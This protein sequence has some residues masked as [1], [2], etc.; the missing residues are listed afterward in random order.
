MP[1]RRIR[2][3]AD[4]SV[5]GGAFD[6]E[7][8][9]P[10][11]RL[12]EDIRQGRFALVTSA[13]VRDELV[14]APAEVGALFESLTEGG[15]VAEVTPDAVDLRDAY[16]RAAIVSERR[17]TDALHV[18]LATVSRCTVLVSW[19][20]RHIVHFQKVPLYNAVSRVNG[21]GEI[22]I[23]SPPEVAL[24]AKDEGV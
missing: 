15:D 24:Y 23:C 11:R 8:A 16:V 21:Y 12:V 3:Y 14:D 7:F 10:S 19:N 20:F 4:T 5:F 18:A 6:E 2:L 17:A 9:E 22:L 1:E 13:L